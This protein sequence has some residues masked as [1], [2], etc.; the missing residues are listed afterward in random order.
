MDNRFVIPVKCKPGINIPLPV[1]ILSSTINHKMGVFGPKF[2][3]PIGDINL[4]EYQRKVLSDSFPSCEIVLG[5]GKGHHKAHSLFKSEWSDLGVR[6]IEN[7]LW[8][9][10]SEVETLRLALNILP[11]LE[12]VLFISGDVLFDK[13]TIDF[14]SPYRSSTLYYMEDNEDEIGIN[15]D[16]SKDNKLSGVGYCLNAKWG[17]ITYLAGKELDILKKFCLPKNGKLEMWEFL[18]YMIKNGGNV[19]CDPAKG[20]IKRAYDSKKIKEMECVG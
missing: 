11:N 18:N 8:E 17:H 4:F 20:Y 9:K 1:I 7:Q 5:I 16:K 2:S 19:A 3:H 6:L 12:R 13:P 15:F 14:I 10:T